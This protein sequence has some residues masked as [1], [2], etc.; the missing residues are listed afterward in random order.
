[1]EPEDLAGIPPA[2]LPFPV[3]RAIA[4]PVET[5]DGDGPLT[6]VGYFSTFGD[7]YEVNS[8]IE[9]RFLERVQHGAFRKTLA[10]SKPK[11][12]FNHGQDSS[13]GN[14]ILGDPSDLREDAKG[15]AYV[16][17]LFDGVPP[18]IVSGLRANAYGSSHRFAAIQDVWDY[19]AKPSSHNPDGLPE[20]TITEARVFE[21][22]P[23]TFPADPHATAGLRST[24]DDYYQRSRDPDAFETLLRSA[25]VART[26]ARAEAAAE[27]SEP[28]TATRETGPEEPD[29]RGIE[30]IEPPRPKE[31]PPVSTDSLKLHPV[32]QEARIAEL[33]ASLVRQDEEMTG[34]PS[35]E[36]QARWDA[37]TAELAEL[38][39]ARAARAQ[40]RAVLSSIDPTDEKRTVAPFNVI[41]TKSVEDIYDLR[42]IENVPYE[43]RR[44]A[45][46]DN[47]MRSLES[48][49]LPP[50]VDKS[51]VAYFLDNRDYMPKD[52]DQ[53]QEL[54]KRILLTGSPAYRRAF[55]KYL[56][57]NRDGWTAEEQRA[58]A[59]AVTGTTTTG[60]YAVPYVF[61][62]TI[63]RI[64]A[65]TAVNPYRAACRV[66]TISGGNNW[67]AV[68]AGAIT[69]KW[70]AEAAASV[71]GGPTFG[72]PTFTVQ[73]AD[74]FATVSIET[75]QDR[76]D[77]TGELS[78][79]FGEAKDTLEENSFTLGVGTTV[80][81]QGMFLSGAFTVQSTA[82][83]DV[84]AISD[85][86]LLEA[87]LPLRERMAPGA[88]MFMSRSTQ[89]QLEALDTTG[90]Y[91][92][93]PGQIA[94]PLG[95]PV[96]GNS[97]T[98]N[99]GTQVLGYPIWEV[100]SAVS[101][102][103][104]DAAVIV[105]FCNPRNYVIVDRIGMNVEV[106]PL[107]LNGATPSFPTGQ[108]GVYCY[109]R[110]TARVLYAD[111][112]RQLDVN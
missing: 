4:D 18:L 81:P 108:R 49:Q 13:I 46:R 97:P 73:R 38:R 3:T 27:S 104:T 69:A 58:A 6:M 94:I 39:A 51:G 91:F 88:A 15:P 12:L 63:I 57:G 102:L 52:G 53:D 101:T 66:E 71:E 7:W 92:K 86:Q 87:A 17:P 14:Q 29:T 5:R 10:E 48:S 100:P 62:P 112:G 90:Y 61:D 77:I 59:L 28:P 30:P 89:R 67:R 83:N 75:L 109:W 107:M 84:T 93:R 20:R 106:V 37:D 70:D 78:L 47:A 34:I 55:N 95:M 111:G 68:T 2:R 54:A 99:T 21:F 33:E 85:L 32:E 26:S 36:A 105:V 65:H 40:R 24:T 45:L 60:G 1:M 79:I 25:Q 74:A 19:R 96:I 11:V 44:Q 41:R 76:P 16:V 31:T 35:V 98:G 72:Q 56:Q 9:G 8:K 42:A 23:V 50:G 80:Y 43:N 22:G 82:T 110:G 64:G 103:T